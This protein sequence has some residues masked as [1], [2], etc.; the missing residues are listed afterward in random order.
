[1]RAVWMSGLGYMQT[2]DSVKVE[3]GESGEGDV[4]DES[5]GV[6]WCVACKQPFSSSMVT[7]GGCVSVSAVLHTALRACCGPADLSRT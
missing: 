2:V 5:S 4:F 3:K 7:E 6:V 1:M